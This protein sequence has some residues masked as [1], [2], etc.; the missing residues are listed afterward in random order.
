M[1]RILFFACAT[2]NST[3]I[4][5]NLCAGQECI[6]KWSCMFCIDLSEGTVENRAFRIGGLGFT[7]WSLYCTLS[8]NVN[9][10]S[11]C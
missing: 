3:R 4:P 5:V 10:V 7:V 6:G 1:D 9:I 2:N 11:Q 8:C